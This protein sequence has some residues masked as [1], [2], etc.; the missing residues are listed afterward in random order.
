[1]D[2]DLS[3]ASEEEE[4]EIGDKPEASTN[5]VDS[6][7]SDHSQPLPAISQTGH[8]TVDQ[9]KKDLA[10]SDD[11][12]TTSSDTE[13]TSTEG[14]V[15]DTNDVA[16]D[17]SATTKIDSEQ[18]KVN[19]SLTTLWSQD[20]HQTNNETKNSHGNN[21]HHSNSSRARSSLTTRSTTPTLS[22]TSEDE[23]PTPR[24][25]PQI[26]ALPRPAEKKSVSRCSSDAEMQLEPPKKSTKRNVSS[27][28]KKEK[29]IL[30][31]KTV[32]RGRPPKRSVTSK[33]Q[34]PESKVKSK[35][36]ILTSDDDSDPEIPTTNSSEVSTRRSLSNRKKSPRSSTTTTTT[37]NIT[38]TTPIQQSEN[39]KYFTNQSITSRKVHKEVNEPKSKGKSNSTSSCG[40]F[41][42]VQYLNQAE[43]SKLNNSQDTDQNKKQLLNRLYRGKGSKGADNQERIADKEKGA[44]ASA[45]IVGK[46]KGNPERDTDGNLKLK[47][48]NTD[49]A[50]ESL[51]R[52]KEDSSPSRST[53]KRKKSKSPDLS[54]KKSNRGRKRKVDSLAS[55]IIETKYNSDVNNKKSKDQNKFTHQ[56]D[57]M[58]GRSSSRC[59]VEASSHLSNS[60]HSQYGDNCDRVPVSGESAAAYQTRQVLSTTGS[61]ELS[62]K[63]H[64]YSSINSIV[65]SD[66][67]THESRSTTNS[68][69]T[70]PRNGTRVVASHHPESYLPSISNST[71]RDTLPVNIPYPIREKFPIMA[72]L[73]GL[74]LENIFMTLFVGN[75]VDNVANDHMVYMDRAKKLK[76][77]ADGM[78][79]DRTYQ[80]T[81]YIEAV[82]FFILS[83]K[84]METDSAVTQSAV[85]MYSDTIALIQWVSSVF[86]RTSHNIKYPNQ[87][88]C[89]A[90]L[91]VLCL[92]CQCIL[93][94]K[95]YSMRQYEIRESKLICC[96]YFNKRTKEKHLSSGTTPHHHSSNI[97]TNSNNNAGH[98]PASS[99][100]ALSPTPSPAGSVNSDSSHSSG[101][102]TSTERRAAQGNP[103]SATP[104][105]SQPTQAPGQAS[106]P[107]KM[108]I[109]VEL[110]EHLMRYYD[111][112]RH[113]NGAEDWWKEAQDL[114]KEHH[115]EGRHFSN[116]N[117]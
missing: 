46:G 42:F 99:P 74:D 3:E 43:T 53:K 2:C 64:K 92:L 110:H 85:T 33:Y 51:K 68:H 15:A 80:G 114:I 102:N 25:T 45:K 101:Y 10:F 4:G 13:S 31:Q 41:S 73:Q 47:K 94:L 8:E 5:E 90:K 40:R 108:E 104:S 23:A 44:N 66:D 30:K 69:Q 54:S 115:L 83:G 95:V 87:L 70:N 21:Q 34:L 78:D 49:A 91:A 109:P 61:A 113:L 75:R 19:W 65:P 107:A 38:T 56:S 12:S 79:S 1:M 76:R 55:E 26:I 52:P 18:S 117:V 71:E 96:D 32:G 59:S 67:T 100:S 106:V 11:E 98:R 111:V 35:A 82:L 28:S 36:F 63:S 112:T 24:P 77:D 17:E 93:S 48:D 89:N 81:K 86:K 58:S 39:K 62:S 97:T 57:A 14:E 105:P 60:P 88:E 6:H 27:K 9:V 116:L 20:D 103:R 16:F 84:A 72:E 37:T 29:P 7:I 22:E 50:I